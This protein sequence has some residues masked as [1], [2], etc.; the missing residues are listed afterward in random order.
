MR[1]QW[2][3]VLLFVLTFVMFPFFVVGGFFVVVG[4]F[5]IFKDNFRFILETNPIIFFAYLAYVVCY[6]LLAIV[7]WRLVQSLSGK[8]KWSF[9]LR[10]VLILMTVIALTIGLSAAAF[11]GK[12]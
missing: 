10:T 3:N 4:F 9:S 5:A 6:S 12:Y 2:R 8:R 7:N 1:N 11:R